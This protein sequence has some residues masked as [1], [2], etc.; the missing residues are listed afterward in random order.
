MT[1]HEDIADFLLQRDW[2]QIKETSNFIYLIHNADEEVLIK[3]PIDDKYSDYITFMHSILEGLK[4]MYPKSYNHPKSRIKYFAHKLDNM[5]HKYS[6][7]KNEWII[8]EFESKISKIAIDEVY[9][10]KKL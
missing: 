9:V 5:K 6:K 7:K 1:L 8:V 10:P 4:N 2:E 3:I